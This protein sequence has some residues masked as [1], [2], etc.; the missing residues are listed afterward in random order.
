[1]NN[2]Y[3]HSL[4]HPDAQTKPEATKLF[5]TLRKGKH[6]N[7]STVWQVGNSKLD[8]IYVVQEDL[9]L[10]HTLKTQ[11]ASHSEVFMEATVATVATELL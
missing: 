7:T 1:L 5:E 8:F 3:T 2:I 10:W 9:T 11:L 4:K 6:L